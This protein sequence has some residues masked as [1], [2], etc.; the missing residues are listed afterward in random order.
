MATD[1]NGSGDSAYVT[2]IS[3]DRNPLSRSTDFR[4][5]LPRQAALGSVFL[6][7]TLSSGF[8]EAGIATVTLGEHRSEIV[9]KVVEYLMYKHEY[10]SSKEEIPDFKQRVKP[11]IALELSVSPEWGVGITM[12]VELGS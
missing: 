6:A 5:I 2:L 11:E 9:E 10:A 7:D 4:Y 8:V 12:D 1:S 3:S